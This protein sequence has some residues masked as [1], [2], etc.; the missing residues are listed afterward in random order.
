MSP[1][2]SFAPARVS[3]RHRGFWPA[4]VQRA[5]LPRRLNALAI[6][7]AM[8]AA[9]SFQPLTPAQAAAL[10]TQSHDARAQVSKF[11]SQSGSDPAY[12]PPPKH[13]TNYVAPTPKSSASKGSVGVEKLNLR[14]PN[15]R[16]FTGSGRQLITDI[17]A[18]SVNYRDA[19]GAWQAVDNG[20][21]KSNQPQYG[22]QNKAN[23]Y[24]LS[25]PTDIGGA[26][27]RIQVGSAWATFTLVGAH[28]SV[29]V[30]G[31]TA[32]YRNALP[33]VSVMVSPLADSVEEGLVLQS[34]SA[35]Q[36][37]S[38]QIQTSSGLKVQSTGNRIS[39]VDSAGR[40]FLVLAAPAMFDS[41][42]KPAR[43][44]SIGLSP[45]TNGSTTTV[46][47]KADPSW[48]QDRGRQWPVTIDP[49]FIISDA[50]DCFINAGSPTSSFCGGTSLNAGFDGTSAS[51]A[52]A[53]FNLQAIPSTDTVLSA[54]LFLYMGSATTSNAT[55][56]SLYQLTRAWTSGATW[57]AYDG[58]NAWTNPGGDFSG[59][60]AATTNG[61]AATGQWYTWSPTALVQGWVNGSIAND[62]LIVKEPTESTTNVLSFNSGTGTNPP[63]LQI[64]HEQGGSTPGTY[65]STVQA[66]S[67]VAYWHLDESSGTTMN[68]AENADPGTYQGGYTLGQSS[69]I[70]PASGNSVSFNGSTG[71]ATA[72]ALTTLQGDN[73]RSIELW[74]QTSSATAQYLVD[75]GANWYA[76]NQQFSLIVAP[77]GWITNNPPINTPGLYLAFDTQAIYW[78]GLYLED[79][80]RHHL[81]LE[82]SGNNIWLYVDGTTPG[83]YFT[84]QG[85]N[86]GFA[87]SWSTRY[88]QQQ[89]ITLTTTPNTGANPI[90]IGNGRYNG[91][92]MLNGKIDEVAVYSTALSATQVQNHWQ[93]G[94]G[95][96]WSPTNV[97]AT[98]G[99]NQAMISWTAPTFNGSGI[100][101]YV[102][103]PQVGAS[104]RTPLTFNSAATSQTVTNLSGGTS[105][106]FTV[107]PFNSLGLGVPSTSS[108]AITPS[109]PALP[110]YE[111]TVMADSPVGF[112][113]LGETSFNV[114]TDL[115][116][117]ANGQFFNGYALGDAGPVINYPNKAANFSGTYANVRLNHT[118]LLEPAAVTVE[119][120]VKP[121][122]IPA[123]DTTIFIS[124]QSGTAEW[125]TNGYLMTFDGFNN[126]QGGKVTWAG[127]TTASA[128]PV[129]AWSYVVGVIDSTATR[130]YVNGK[131]AAAVGGGSPNYG[132]PANFDALVTRY[133]FQGDL[134][135]LAVYSSSLSAAQVGAHWAVA[136]YAPGP[137]SNLVATA[138]TNSASLTWTAPS[139]TGTSPV[140][141]YT[142][143][144][145]VDG[146]AGTPVT[147][148]GSGTGANIANLPGGASY[149]FEVQANNASGAGA[150]VT[151]SAVTI[152]APAAGPGNFGTYLYM[153][154]GPGQ[155]QAFAHYGFVSRNNV[156][157]MS[158]WTLEEELW[159]FNSLSTTGGHA[160]LGL[161]S[162]TPSSPTDQNPI[163][164][165]NFN[166]GGNPLQSYFVW[167]GGS[168]TL[169]SGAGGLPLAITGTTPAHVAISYDG[170][171]IRGFIN[172]T[173][174]SGCSV[175]TG[176]A[177]VPAA[178]FGFFDSSGLNGANFDEFRVSSTARYTANFTPP[179]SQFTT[180]ASTLILWHFN[181]YPISKLPSTHI[182]PGQKSDGVNYDGVII[183]STY[184]DSSG[185]I[186]HANT[187]WSTGN[188]VFSPGWE[189]W[190]RPYSL[191]QG[192]T[193]DELTGGASNWLCPCTISSTARP[194]NDATGEFY[195]T[196]TDFHVPGRIDLDFTRTY[197]SLRT[198]T[199]GPTG[200]GWT[201]NYNQY[202]TFD[203]SGNATV[204]EAN[205]SAVV[206]TFTAPSTYTGPP[207][208]HV[209]LVKNGDSTFTLTDAGQNQTV[210][211]PAVSNLST[212]KKIVDRHGTA[213]YTLTM[214]Y[215]GDGTLASVTDPNGRMLTF[216]YTTIGT[217]KLIQTV[218]QNDS[219]SRSVSFQYG[220]NSGD[221]TTYLS[222]TQVT[223]VASGLT[224]FTYDSNHYL[225]TMTDPN[226][227][228]TTNTYDPSTHQVT[229]QQDPITSR[230]T[231]FSYSGG[232]A[233]I[234]DPKG[235]VTQEEYINGILMSR[236]IGYGTAQAATWTYSFDPAAVGLTASVG[237]SGETVTTVRD[238]NANVLSETDGLGRT[239]NYTY[240]SFSEPLTIQDPTQV[241]TTN[242]YNATGDLATTSRPL[243]GTQQVQTVTYNH[244]DSS[245]PGDVTSMVD[246][247]NFTWTY[248]YDGNGYRNSVTDPLGD[249]TTYVFNA[250]SWMTSS[251]APNQYLTRQDTFVRT[252]VSGSWGTATDGNVWTKQAG[253]ATYSTNGTQ[254]VIAKPS[255]DSYESL[256]AALANDGGEVLVR[257]QVSSTRDKAGAVLRMSASANTFYG[258]RFNASGSVEL[259][260][261]WGG[262]VHTNIGGVQVSYTPGTAKQWFRFRV[263]GSTLYFKV[264]ADG[265]QEPASW[266]GQTTDTN[267]TGTGFA[268]LYGN[269]TTTTGVKFD[270]FSANPYATT[271][272]TYNSF[273]QRTGLTDPENHTTSW[274]YDPN[275]NLDRVTDADN[276]LTTN[277][278]DADNELT[279]VKRADSPQTTLTTDYNP[280]GTVLDQKDGKGNAIQTYAYDSLAHVTT[281]TDALNNVTTYV[282]DA[283]GNLLSKQDP[284]G[285]CGGTPPTGCTTYSYD[286]ANQLTGIN[287]SDGVT[288][289]VSNITYDGD[290]QRLAMSD[291]TGTSSF[292]WDS[293]HRMVSYQ[294][295]NGA[296]VAWIYNLRNLATTITYPGSLN[297]TRGYDNAGRWTSVQDWNSN[298]TSFGY[299]ADSNLTTETFPS[300]SAIVDTFTFNA[301]DQMTNVA[302]VKGGSTTLFSA[303]YSRDSANQLT[304]D[305]S[306][307]S[308]TGS[309]KYTPLNQVCY[310][311]SSTTNACSSLPS[312][313]IAYA[314]DAADNL[315]Q[316]GSV[317]QAFNNADELCWS[318][319]SSAA[320]GSPPSGA[321][322]YQFDTR[323]NRTNVTPN[324][325][326]AQTLTYDQANR[327]TKFAAASTTSYGYNGDGLRMCKYAGSSTQPC[328]QGGATQFLW[329]VAGSL[330]VLLKDGTTAYIYGPGGLPVEQVNTSATYWYH[331]DQIGSTRL[332]TDS[333]GTSQATYTYDPYGGLASSTGSLTNPFLYCGEYRDSESGFYYLRA[334]YFEPSTGQFIS[335]DAAVAATRSPY[336]YVANNPLNASDPS[337]LA[338]AFIIC[339]GGLG[340]GGVAGGGLGFAG[341]QA[342]L[343]GNVGIFAGGQLGTHVGGTLSGAAFAY[344]GP[345][346]ACAPNANDNGNVGLAGGAGANVWFSNAT[347]ASQ[348]QGNF[349]AVDVTAGWKIG[350]GVNIQWDDH[351]TWIV[352]VTPPIPG[353]GLTFGGL[354]SKYTSNTFAWGDW[355]W[356]WSH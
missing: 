323:G 115:T 34:A 89:P 171:T 185:N 41:A 197:S 221:P 291:G 134:A 110:L 191:G 75:A 3:D 231:T 100:T 353:N 209:T 127:I 11:S 153:R 51:R 309:Y 205:G 288:P 29:S 241:T 281:V 180:D 111:D 36:D 263:A 83:A 81:V 21:V 122:T 4:L 220:T 157:V 186:N 350:G 68:D 201:D 334:R 66:D 170:T 214:A 61:I 273:G 296:Q 315:T 78:P 90:L 314:Y 26:P 39:I 289:N 339:S 218:T 48:L 131:Q 65:A 60:A 163:A 300:A 295:G 317:Q 227:G 310:A 53:E 335:H 146:N 52:L 71:Y 299:D 306:A 279:Q 119:L 99:Q 126:G 195:H 277:V 343:N 56:L 232:T 128:L 327:L 307:A 136:G 202:L 313:S 19:G 179:T 244:A 249:K 37:F 312:G 259:F 155:G 257:W 271:T 118:T 87:S 354:V 183:P 223:D 274:H 286:A 85:G 58:T 304:T 44:S 255:S 43:T 258:V 292:G 340:A 124:P 270:Q 184:R 151:S 190:R 97:T 246:A 230:A 303:G 316:K 121:S 283:Y 332:I 238:S 138:S 159:G 272:Y 104:L 6:G 351:G 311:G 203:G 305:S 73:T 150:I 355:H 260:G 320:C 196:F 143:T 148:S 135:D 349:H 9:V 80:K 158:S 117:T 32:T 174:V 321:T 168:C 2:Q 276:N 40:P 156:P 113:P 112:W 15:S 248:T 18:Q 324:G 133:A 318:A 165:L 206:F 346:H 46:T 42:K 224:R 142:V 348:L 31:S 237:P 91:T 329:D 345:Y 137:V 234:T 287:Y 166:I 177:A 70:Q 319:S 278:Y 264:W 256:G 13:G 253:S 262:T 226:N 245:H 330:P 79:G 141:S 344:A 176:S 207:D 275:Q 336:G 149:T 139:Y 308:G 144:P 266:T 169:P 74:F 140:T 301:A 199:L 175:A 27:I 240:N 108:S 120:W 194:V 247:D 326:Q 356:P 103:T 290:G 261:K 54:K 132:G 129:G 173:L 233:T 322:T 10:W 213:A 12:E 25:L 341:A 145:V 35:A 225:Q 167:P 162:G 208:E 147:V 5:I 30:S 76:V 33:G 188:G 86:D 229:K 49:T 215:N 72:P 268:G 105:Y 47:L 45:S 62:G 107:T 228:V 189:D 130:I 24:A 50:L 123:N 94:N 294:N 178:P 57:N 187:V 17:Y 252:P 212:L 154:G 38:Y 333:T 331:H 160:A 96:P 95:L 192:V 88:L 64:V 337:G 210:F 236:T 235:N 69:L 1:K 8:L 200:Y 55:S 204:H 269:A 267:V 101:G 342:T 325:G 211:N 216:A 254:G 181:D 293:L 219:P 16:T 23:R 67:P 164:G 161:L 338:C 172:G 285:N 280:D 82:V 93:A 302:S 243:V 7:V 84:N 222:L 63:Y 193:A 98:A 250:D 239:M 77:Q 59:A 328:Q 152:K 251:T 106:S 182:I 297:V 14:T 114:A 217:S 28:G 198:A 92:N 282:Y 265:S 125:S 284:G 242:T 352:S 347:S 298:T 109:G 20:L 102:I 22:Y 116:Q